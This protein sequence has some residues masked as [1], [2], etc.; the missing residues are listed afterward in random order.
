MEKGRIP[1]Q[2]SQQY[3]NWQPPEVGSGHRV[4]AGRDPADEIVA[5]HLTARDLETITQQAHEECFGHGREEGHQAGYADGLAAGRVA[6]KT[7]LTTQMAQLRQVMTSLLEPTQAQAAAIEQALSQLAVDIAHA[8]LRREPALAAIDLLPLVRSAVRELPVGSR[9]ICVLLNPAE[10]E[11]MR[12]CAEWPAAWQMQADSRIEAGG[13]RVHSASSVVDYTIGLRFR[14]V[15]ERILA[16]HAQTEAPEPGLL[17][18]PF[19][20]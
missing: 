16:D 17:M 5:R 9:N 13:C 12:A 15:A 2:D 20:E 19:D 3:P 8:V 18:E 6:A 10:L 7:E 1:A 4:A 11:L 14:Q